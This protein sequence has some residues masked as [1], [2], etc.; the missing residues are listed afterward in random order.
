M[1]ANTF[2]MRHFAKTDLDTHFRSTLDLII[3]DGI[4]TNTYHT[5][6]AHPDYSDEPLTGFINEPAAE[7]LALAECMG[8]ES[9]RKMYKIILTNGVHSYTY[10]ILQDSCEAAEEYTH[11]VLSPQFA[12]LWG[13]VPIASIGLEPYPE[14]I[15]HGES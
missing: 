9:I 5:D 6:L 8:Y 10:Y 4:V 1:H 11:R 14:R 3:L 7:A 2:D 15:M 13:G 12:N